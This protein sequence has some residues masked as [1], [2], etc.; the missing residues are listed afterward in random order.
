MLKA[1]SLQSSTCLG[2]IPLAV[3][4][5][6]STPRCRP[7]IE[8]LDL[9]L[10]CQ[11]IVSPRIPLW[12]GRLEVGFNLCYLGFELLKCSEVGCNFAVDVLHH[13][14]AEGCVAHSF[15]DHALDLAVGSL[16][17]L[18]LGFDLLGKSLEF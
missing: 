6:I 7:A 2:E 5:V 17:I 4:L 18:Y 15:S 1:C 12:A 14:L 13:L 11:L 8:P 9:C 10:Q 3:P 16:H